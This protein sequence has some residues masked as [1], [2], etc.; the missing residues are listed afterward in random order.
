M[1]DMCDRGLRLDAW[2]RLKINWPLPKFAADRLQR[3]LGG[4]I[5]REAEIEKAAGSGA[6]IAVFGQVTAGLVHHPERR[7]WLAPAGQHFEKGLTGGA[8]C[9]AAFP[10]LVDN[11]DCQS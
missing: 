2:P 9:Q 8:P 1:F 11:Y 6:N 3:H 4:E 10:S 7:N 5:R